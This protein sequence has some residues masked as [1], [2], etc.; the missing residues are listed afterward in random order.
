MNAAALQ[1]D[2]ATLAAILAMAL[3]T[4]ATRYGGLL[5]IRLMT[6]TGRTR[7]M[8][9]AIPAAVLTAVVTPTALATGAAES[10]ACLVTVLAAQR[11]SLLPSVALGI[12]TVVGLRAAGL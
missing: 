5:L 1:V 7:R 8:L 2:P 11:L 6:P 9:E 3:A 10:A 12:G 4:L